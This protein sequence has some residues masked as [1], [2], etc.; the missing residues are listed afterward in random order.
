MRCNNRKKKFTN[1]SYKE[2]VP[3]YKN[4]ANS[5]R[6]THILYNKIKNKSKSWYYRH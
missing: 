3:H 2:T 5:V 6:H 4:N 1:H